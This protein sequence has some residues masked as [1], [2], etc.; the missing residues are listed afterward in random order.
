MPQGRKPTTGPFETRVEFERA[1]HQKRKNKENP[2]TVQA[3]ADEFKVSGAT[4]HKILQQPM[5]KKP[6]TRKKAA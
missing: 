3:I 1:V 4:I 6:R 5:P 2:M